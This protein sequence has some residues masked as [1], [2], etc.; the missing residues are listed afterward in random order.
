MSAL[1]MTGFGS[2]SLEIND[3]RITIEI[4]SL[5]NKYFD[6]AIKIPD[7]L[8][9]IEPSIKE[10]LAK[11]IKRG[12]VEIKIAISASDDKIQTLIDIDGIKTLMVAQ[13]EIKKYF[14]LAKDLS[15]YE[16]MNTPL[17]TNTK[18]QDFSK[19]SQQTLG[20]IKKCIEN[21]LDSCSREGERLQNQILACTKNIED[22]TSRASKLAPEAERMIRFRIKTRLL[23]ATSDSIKEFFGPEII[24]NQLNK[25]KDAKIKQISEFLEERLRIEAALASSK[26]DIAEELERLSCHT[27]EIRRIFSESNKKAIGKRLDFIAQEMHREANT[28]GSKSTT[29]DLNKISIEMRLLIDQIKEQV[30][31]IQ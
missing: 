25:L 18:E 23:E 24:D 21:F 17:V 6:C 7:S 8:K 20:S 2:E 9:V 26:I 10:M 1:S 15:V 22:L 5:N 28:I 3:G 29:I 14:P 12:K 19:I 13:S 27:T 31:N 30:Q 16:V 4:K 11:N